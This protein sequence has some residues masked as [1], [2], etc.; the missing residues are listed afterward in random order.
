MGRR[1][2]DVDASALLFRTRNQRRAELARMG[3][4]AGAGFAMHRARRVFASAERQA[5]LDQQFELRTA[6]QV[7]EALGGMKGAF[8]KLGQMASYLDVGLPDHAREALAGL[9]QDAPPMS[10]ELAAGVIERELGERPERLFLEWDPAPLASASIGQVHRAIT[11]DGRAVAV[12]VQYPGV[13]EAIAADLDSAGVVFGAM[14][15]AFSGFDPGPLVEEIR[16]RV[17]EELDYANEARN[18]QLFADTYRDHPF[19]HVPDVVTELSTP[20]VLTTDLAEGVR[21]EEMAGWSQ[22]E[23]NR[24]AEAIYRFVFRSLYRLNAFNGD[25]HPGNYLFQPGGRV[26]F[27]DFGLVKHFTQ[28]EIE[29]FG[30]MIRALVLEGD[31]GRYRRIIES[32]GLLKPGTPVSDE[33]VHEYFSHFYEFVLHDEEVTITPE[34]STAAVSRFFDPTGPHGP[35]IKAANLPPSFVIIQRINLGLMAILGDLRATANFRRIADELWPW[36]DGPP[37]TEMGK[38]EADW[39]ADRRT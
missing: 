25:P 12:K 36:V 34:W 39:L 4:R 7:A 38:A 22:D 8:M 28:P 33:Q 23:R 15:L 37:S 31:T 9:Q 10:A 21:F 27:L 14:G 17:I 3:G 35:I 20:R 2:A 19:I 29:T 1:S 18:Q 6:E 24:A 13:D 26:T 16:A 11:R 32:I 30:D 5:E